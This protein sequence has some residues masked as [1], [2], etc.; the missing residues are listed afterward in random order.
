M[1]FKETFCSLVQ[2]TY[3]YGT[4][5]EL[6]SNLPELIKDRYG[7]YYRIIGNPTTMFTSH[8]DTYSTIQE[9]VR[10]REVIKDNELFI[11]STSDTILGADGKAGVT[12]MMYMMENNITG[13]YYFFIGGER[14]GIGSNKVC[15]SINELS[16][17]KNINKVIS[18]DRRGYD[19]V[20]TQQMDQ[21]CC[22]ELFANA[23]V[24]E[25]NNNGMYY[26]KD[27]SGMFTD[28]ANFVGV[29]PEC[30]N[31]SVGFFEEHTEN[32]FVNLTF[33]EKLSN[34]CLNINWESLPISFNIS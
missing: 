10:V 19:S 5:F 29:I 7:N 15:E 16:Y 28:S 34:A 24:D 23:L 6:L 3:P 20:I 13:L 31:I 12:L 1:N 30:T 18:F 4:E 21:E 32:E 26:R 25:L 22:S 8:L 33:L 17:L 9:K 27:P 14:W 11:K 2:Y